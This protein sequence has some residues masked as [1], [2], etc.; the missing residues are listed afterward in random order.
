MYHYVYRITNTKLNKHYYGK[1]S[2]KILPEQDIGVYYF[3]SSTDAKFKQDQKVNPH[4]YKYKVIKTFASSKKAVL[5]EIKLHNKFDVG[6]NSRFY[7]RAKQV[8]TDYDYA[9]KISAQ[10]RKGVPLSEKHKI[11]ISEGMKGKNSLNKKQYVNIYKYKTDE[12]LAENVC[13]T[14]WC[15]EHPEYS[16]GTLWQTINADRTKKSCATNRLHH[17][18]I[19]AQKI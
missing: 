14:D 7:N 12:L 16:Q 4:H 15:K 13:I 11:N 17:K 18:Q 10:M 8:L 1:R 5:Y 2:S 6:K 3:S 19:Y 9:I